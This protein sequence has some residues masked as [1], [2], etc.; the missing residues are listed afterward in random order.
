MGCVLNCREGGSS[1]MNLT[2]TLA[3]AVCDLSEIDRSVWLTMS[4]WLDVLQTLMNVRT[5]VRALCTPSLVSILLEATHVRVKTAMSSRQTL[6][7]VGARINSALS[8]NNIANLWQILLPHSTKTCLSFGRL[9]HI[10]WHSHV[11]FLFHCFSLPFPLHLYTR[12]A[13]RSLV[14]YQQT[15][16]AFLDTRCFSVSHVLTDVQNSHAHSTVNL[17]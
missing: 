13:Y 17:H 5:T 12:L 3:H 9:R 1:M 16:T 11:P 14:L 2:L 7:S 4:S 8:L 10:S 6:V 15:V